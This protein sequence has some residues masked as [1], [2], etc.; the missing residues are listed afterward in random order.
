MHLMSNFH[1]MS[2]TLSHKQY[3]IQDEDEVL[4]MQLHSTCSLTGETC[5]AECAGGYEHLALTTAVSNALTAMQDAQQ[6][7]ARVPSLPSG[8]DGGRRGQAGAA[9]AP[10]AASHLWSPAT[11]GEPRCVKLQLLCAAWLR[12]LSRST[13]HLGASRHGFDVAY[14]AIKGAGQLGMHAL[15]AANQA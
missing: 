1:L 9:A 11:R 14:L 10:R 6:C 7:C 15:H 4:G 12:S 2:D 13:G 3:V 5:T 8:G